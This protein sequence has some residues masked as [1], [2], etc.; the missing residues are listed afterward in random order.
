MATKWLSEL[1]WAV[2]NTDVLDLIKVK[3]VTPHPI[4]LPCLRRS[5]FAQAG[6]WGEGRLRHFL[7]NKPCDFSFDQDLQGPIKSGN[8]LLSPF[9]IDGDGLG[10]YPFTVTA[11]VTIHVEAVNFFEIVKETIQL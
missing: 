2:S 10:S 9:L 3:G 11:A 7:F 5:G 1:R 8:H 4:P 6:Q